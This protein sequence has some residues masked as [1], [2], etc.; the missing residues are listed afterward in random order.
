MFL[1][2]N[3]MRNNLFTSLFKNK[4]NMSKSLEIYHLLY[5]TVSI[6]HRTAVRSTLRTTVR[7]LRNIRLFGLFV[8]FWNC[9]GLFGP[10]IPNSRTWVFGRTE[11]FCGTGR[12]GRSFVHLSIR[13]HF[14]KTYFSSWLWISFISLVDSSWQLWKSDMSISIFI[15]ICTIALL[16]SAI[17]EFWSFLKFLGQV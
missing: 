3:W 8:N 15:F 11:V 10:N 16:R 7:D 1:L 13:P 4:I 14:G 5:T 17:L 2:E 9:T 6:E 12:Y